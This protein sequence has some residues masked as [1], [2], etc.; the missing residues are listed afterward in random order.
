MA[1]D[2]PNSPTVGQIYSAEGIDWIWNG[3]TWDTKPLAFVPNDFTL[4]DA[5]DLSPSVVSTS[6]AVRI[7]ALY[8]GK[9]APISISGSGEYQTADDSA[10]SVNAS[11]WKTAAGLILEGQYVRTRVTTSSSYNTDVSCTLTIG[12]AGYT[13]SDT[14][15][16]T[17][18]ARIDVFL[19]SAGPGSWPVPGQYNPADNFVE[20]LGSGGNG[21]D[22]HATIG[23]PAGGAGGGGGYARKNNVP[24]G[25]PTAP[26][27][28]GFFGSE[29]WFSSNTTVRASGGTA[30]TPSPGVPLGP[31][32]P[33]G[34]GGAGT[35]GDVLRS[36]GN[37][38]NGGGTR[39][40]GGGG[41]GAAG[42]GGNGGN[43]ADG[44]GA[45]APSN[46]VSG[47]GGGG[48][49]PGG[50]GSPGSGSTGGSGHPSGGGPGGSGNNFPTLSTP[51]PSGIPGTGLSPSHGAGGGGGGGGFGA[52]SGGVGGAR[53]GG[54]G[55]GGSRAGA[56]QPVASTG[57]SG[58]VGIIHI[59]F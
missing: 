30:G 53:G 27:V 5:T 29:T 52:N 35:H 6:S 25:S 32:G 46:G 34:A 50:A 18:R 10:F 58:G 24:L 13:Q 9:A 12:A 45:A 42:S 33:G 8:H 57:G 40:G 56:P 1:L 11:A 31:G 4:P 28:V 49:G 26:Y 41:G 59:Q 44:T 15:N 54:G 2:F 20:L 19:T 48:G 21:G 55:G 38:G 3:T 37:G 51:A 47:G 22:G 23:M 7:S 17:T 36:G 39:G 14:Y 43:G 16:A